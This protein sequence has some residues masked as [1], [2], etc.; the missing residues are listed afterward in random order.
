MKGWDGVGH[1]VDGGSCRCGVGHAQV[2]WVDWVG[3]V[4][5]GWSCS[6]RVSHAG[7]GWVM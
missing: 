4:M 7:E 5:M 6:S 1:A 3:W 2:G